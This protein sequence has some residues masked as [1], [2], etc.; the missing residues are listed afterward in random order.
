MNPPFHVRESRQDDFGALG[1]VTVEVY[2]DD[3]PQ[4]GNHEAH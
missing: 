4:A 3:R 1:Q 2:Y